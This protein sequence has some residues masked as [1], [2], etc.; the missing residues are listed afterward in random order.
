VIPRPVRRGVSNFASNLSQPGYVLNNLLQ[1]RIDDAAKNTLRFA[2]NSTI[3]I[4]G[5]FDPATAMGLPTP[6]NGF[7]RD[8]ACLRPG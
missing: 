2:I 6:R 7:R 4:G 8:H 1:F 5:L 3:G